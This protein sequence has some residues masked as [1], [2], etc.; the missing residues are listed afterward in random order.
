MNGASD[1]PK[2]QP[3]RR[4]GASPR[5]SDR[6]SDLAQWSASHDEVA[7]KAGSRAAAAPLGGH[8]LVTD[9]SGQGRTGH[10]EEGRG[11]G[12]PEQESTGPDWA[13]GAA[14]TQQEF[15]SSPPSFFGFTL[16][17]THAPTGTSTFAIGRRTSRLLNYSVGRHFGR[18]AGPR[19]LD[20]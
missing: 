9:V 6:R 7:C 20:R 15:E 2:R 19:Y 16:S 14:R 5:S 4:I 3:S 17:A 18:A 8:K 1:G 13:D 11:T 10:H 12:V